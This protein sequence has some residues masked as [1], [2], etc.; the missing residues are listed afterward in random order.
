MTKDSLLKEEQKV[1]SSFDIPEDKRPTLKDIEDFTNDLYSNV[2]EN[3]DGN[4]SLNQSDSQL[5]SC[6]LLNDTANSSF[7]NETPQGGI[8]SSNR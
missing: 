2:I 7:K 8:M 3:K 4:E 5:L 6:H 1:I